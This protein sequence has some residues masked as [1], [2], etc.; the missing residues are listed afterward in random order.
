MNRFFYKYGWWMMQIV[1]FL[2]SCLFLI[3][4][5]LILISSYQS[6]DPYTFL[7]I[8]FASNFIILIS[9]ALMIIFIIRIISVFRKIRNGE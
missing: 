3:L 9:G 6:A 1:F 4:G 7:M 2:F 5:V 8:F